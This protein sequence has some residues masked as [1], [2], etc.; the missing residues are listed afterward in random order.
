MRLLY[1]LCDGIMLRRMTITLIGLQ[2]KYP[3]FA[4]EKEEGIFLAEFDL[5]ALRTYR[6]HEM[7]GN[8]FRKVK[9]YGELMKEEIEPPFI[10]LHQKKDAR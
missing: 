8:T 6:E 4:G 9:A 1:Q 3:G 5:P 7:M 2:K 10:R